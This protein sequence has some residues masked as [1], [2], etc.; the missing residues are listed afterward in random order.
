MRERKRKRETERDTEKERKKIMNQK[1]VAKR[2]IPFLLDILFTFQI[3]SPFLVSF[4]KTPYPLPLPLLNNLPTSASWSLH[5]PILGHRTF[6]G[7]RASLRIDEQL[8]QPLLHM[9]LEP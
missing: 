9:Q 7:P 1:H 8:G 2:S 5:S 4:L 6:T 3:L